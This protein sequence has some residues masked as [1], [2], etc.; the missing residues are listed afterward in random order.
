[1]GNGTLLPSSRNRLQ[2]VMMIGLENSR[3]DKHHVILSFK[4]NL[5][6]ISE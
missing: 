3:I 4:L 5:L 6:S 2:E 1:M